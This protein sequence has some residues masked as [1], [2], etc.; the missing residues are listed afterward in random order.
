MGQDAKVRARFYMKKINENIDLIEA[1][2]AQV[3]LLDECIN[4]LNANIEDI[5]YGFFD[6]GFLLHYYNIDVEYWYGEQK[7]DFEGQL[8]MAYYKSVILFWDE[9]SNRIEAIEKKRRYICAEIASLVMDNFKY[10]FF[11]SEAETEM[12]SPD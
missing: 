5:E 1:Y 4:K 10:N 8:M 7:A 2:K 9:I 11:K 6:I 3:E 12:E